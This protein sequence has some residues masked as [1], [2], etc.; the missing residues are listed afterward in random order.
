MKSQ[1]DL[2]AQRAQL[3][4][5]EAQKGW[6]L[7]GNIAGGYQKSPF[8]K[9]PFGRFFDPLVR[10]GL[11]YP[12][13]GSA[14]KQQRAINDAATQVE[15]EDIR[16]DWSKR[17]AALFMEEYYAAYWSA[18]KMLALNEAYL[19]LRSEGVEKKLLERRE[20]GLLLMSDYYEFLSAFEQAE[21]SRIAFSSDKDQAL[22]RLAYLTNRTV[23]PFEAS[24]PDL[25]RIANN[26]STDIDQPDL[27]I[28][29]AQIANLQNARKTENW[30]GI[31]SDFSAVVFGGPAIPHPS[32]DSAQFGYGGAVGFNIRMP[33]EIAKYRKNERSRLN[34]QLSSLHAEY[35]RRDQE[36]G[37]EF[38]TLLSQYHQLVQQLNFQRTRLDAARESVR[39][40]Y[41]RLQV[42][43]G[44]VMEQYLQAINNYYRIAIEYIEAETEQWKLHIRLRQFI[45]LASDL[46]PEESSK[47]EFD[48]ET[49]VVAATASRTVFCTRTFCQC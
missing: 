22:A 48:Q 49:I 31:E 24:K 41:L 36:L 40:R 32:S 5:N 38:D 29:Q 46:G 4:A 18:Q 21:R 12:L 9:E 44:D 3:K 47:A 14:E 7:F 13:L 30:Q 34:S 1:A 25:I 26:A 11:R 42:L 37:L 17:L 28:L 15:I 10:V 35:M 2:D 45:T 39:E 23:M 16:L 27:G 20:T 8:A 43:D 19:H 33:L 6:E